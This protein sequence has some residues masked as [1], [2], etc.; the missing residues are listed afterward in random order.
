MRCALVLLFICQKRDG[1]FEDYLFFR[2]FLSSHPEKAK[3]YEELKESLTKR[4]PNE[5]KNYTAGKAE[6]VDSILSLMVR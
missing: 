6:F 5:R 3:E 1:R 2:D 4:F